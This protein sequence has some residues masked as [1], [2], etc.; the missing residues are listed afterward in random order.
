M[1]KGVQIDLFTHFF[2]NNILMPAFKPFKAK[3]K[4][5]APVKKKEEGSSESITDDE[6]A[7]KIKANKDLET[8]EVMY[9]KHVN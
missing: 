9:T 4:F 3:G 6:E 8:Y 7:K 5:S 1:L 2:D